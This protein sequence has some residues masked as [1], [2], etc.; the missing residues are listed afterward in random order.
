[1]ALS[2]MQQGIVG[3]NN[4]VT[5]IMTLYLIWE[6]IDLHTQVY[7]QTQT[8]LSPESLFNYLLK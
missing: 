7:M 4:G 6:G 5:V 1:M 2:T 3:W 8:G